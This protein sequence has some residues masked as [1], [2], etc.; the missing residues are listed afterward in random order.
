MIQEQVLDN[1]GEICTVLILPTL[2]KR[3]AFVNGQPALQGYITLPCGD[4]Y[5]A[6]WPVFTDWWQ[7]G[8]AAQ[9]G[10]HD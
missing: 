4:S 8:G 3:D 10:S 6:W 2:T 5:K 1:R 7:D 9:G